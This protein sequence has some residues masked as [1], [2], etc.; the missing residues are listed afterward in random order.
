VESAI[1]RARNFLFRSH[2]N[3]RRILAGGAAI[4]AIAG[5]VFFREAP[6]W[7]P[8]VGVTFAIMGLFLLRK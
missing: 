7:Q 3:L 8:I 1:Q 4:R 6:S 2:G 5:I